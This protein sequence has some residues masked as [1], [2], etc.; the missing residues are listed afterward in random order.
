MISKDM[1]KTLKK[2]PKS[3]NKIHFIELINHK[4]DELIVPKGMLEIAMEYKYI[5]FVNNSPYNMLTTSP[6]CFLSLY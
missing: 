3:P 5:K 1:Y 2:I 6:F 4:N